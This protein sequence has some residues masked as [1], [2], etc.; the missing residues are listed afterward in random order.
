MSALQA[1]DAS[2]R[3]SWFLYCDEKRPHGEQTHPRIV[4]DMAREI[5]VVMTGP[6]G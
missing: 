2:S 4:I 3:T 5:G 1:S 6:R